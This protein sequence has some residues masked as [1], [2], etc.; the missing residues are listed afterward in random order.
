[1][2]MDNNTKNN[3]D[4]EVKELKKKLTKLSVDQEKDN[5]ERNKKE[6][7][8]DE[9][10]SILKGGNQI[11]KDKIR[12]KSEDIEAS[13]EKIKLEAEIE[14]F[15]NKLAKLSL[16]KETYVQVKSKNEEELQMRRPDHP[17]VEHTRREGSG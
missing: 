1:M 9:K 17:V 6:E 16:D 8:L 10:V 13:N 7:A 15:K 2:K 4:T 11:L 12:N 5:E 3:L 14:D